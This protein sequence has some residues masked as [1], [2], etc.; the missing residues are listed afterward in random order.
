MFNAD[1]LST[2]RTDSMPEEETLLLP[3]KPNVLSLPRP[4]DALGTFFST[5]AAHK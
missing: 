1:V 5:G 2:I 3:G 4:G